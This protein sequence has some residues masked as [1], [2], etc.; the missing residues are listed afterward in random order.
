MVQKIYSFIFIGKLLE[1]PSHFVDVHIVQNRHDALRLM[2][3]STV[4]N[5]TIVSPNISII[6][7]E[8]TKIVFDRFFAA[9]EVIIN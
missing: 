4:K 1:N 6:V 5:F 9:G 7:T 2:N 3:R 8:K